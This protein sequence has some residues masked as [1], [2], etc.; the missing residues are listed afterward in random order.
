MDTR[1]SKVVGFLYE[2]STP[3][4]GEVMPS[5][6]SRAKFQPIWSR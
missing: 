6:S 5:S 2:H 3:N 4:T 1:S